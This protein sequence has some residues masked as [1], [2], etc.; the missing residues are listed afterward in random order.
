MSGLPPDE[1]KR[2]EYFVI[3]RIYAMDKFKVLGKTLV[4]KGAIVDFYTLDLEAP[5]G[6]I[7][8]WDHIEHKGASAVVPVDE[9][10]KV[11]MVRQYRGAIDNI[12]LEIPAGGRDS[13]E[14]DFM[15]CAARELEEETGYRSEDIRHLIDIHTAAAYTSEKIA[16]YFAENL[17]PSKQKLDEN[18]FVN[19]E[20]FSVEE[21]EK[22]IYAGEITDAKTVA[23]VLAYKNLQS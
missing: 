22:M 2:P 3:R 16:I 13:A 1:T 18:E 6:N 4:H 14:E 10:G 7:A 23:G 21:I 9:N 19:I 15:V 11:L 17:I 8:H 20:R 12:M 5:N